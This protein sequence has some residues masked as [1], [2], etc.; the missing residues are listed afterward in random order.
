M[1]MRIESNDIYD[2]R[3]DEIETGN[4]NGCS[5]GYCD[6]DVEVDD[7]T[8]D[9]D[10]TIEISGDCECFGYHDSMPC[11]FTG[12]LTMDEN[13][14]TSEYTYAAEDGAKYV[15][16][17]GN[18]EISITSGEKIDLDADYIVED[19]FEDTMSN[20]SNNIEEEIYDASYILADVIQSIII[21][22][23]DKVLKE[24]KRIDNIDIDKDNTNE[25]V[26]YVLKNIIDEYC[27][28]LS[29]TKYNSI[30]AILNAQA[31]EDI[32]NDKIASLINDELEEESNC[33]TE[34][35]EITAKVYFSD[36]DP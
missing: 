33:S 4:F 14:F 3:V 26:D 31:A 22:A 13:E 35:F 21:H 23:S 36:L 19:T 1:K 34:T 12:T 32:K 28:E 25:Y 17:E 9:G 11:T 7:V 29:D 6:F 18:I 10:I 30:D 5:E 8:Q 2:I 24:I 27:G 16:F 15:T 20:I